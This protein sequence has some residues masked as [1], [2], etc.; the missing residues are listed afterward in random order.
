MSE[1]REPSTEIIPYTEEA[2][3][4]ARSIIE[5]GGVIGFRTDTF[6]GL[7]CDPFNLQGVRLV[8]RLKEREGIK[9]VLVVISDNDVAG[10]FIAEHT[11][12]FDELTKHYWPGP[13]TIVCK[14]SADVPSGITAGSGT[15][16]LRVPFDEDVRELVRACGGALTATSANTAGQPPSRTATEVA[17]YFPNE[18]TLI[19][20]GGEARTDKPSTVVDI[21]RERPRLIREGEVPR[22]DLER[23]LH[24]LGVELE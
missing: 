6:Y 18:L 10:R 3:S 17:S 15:I 14:A 5:A 22:T 8:N 16:G 9:P 21:T 11:K 19:I 20:D 12:L 1:R 7:G 13:L 23:T 24:I 2:K 4:R